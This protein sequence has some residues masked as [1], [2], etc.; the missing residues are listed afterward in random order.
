MKKLLILLLLLAPSFSKAEEPITPDEVQEIKMVIL[1]TISPC[2]APPYDQQTQPVLVDIDV[3][4]DGHL[5]FA[6]FTDMARY[7]SDPNYKANAD[8]VAKAI[9]DPR[10]N[11]LQEIPH[12]DK[13]SQWRN[14]SL[15]FDMMSS[16]DLLIDKA[17]NWPIGI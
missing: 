16:N 2:W 11:S 12:P 8:M 14:L 13:F 5:T 6:G 7:S 4:S 17:V 15:V 10:C 3:E 9:L 1:Q